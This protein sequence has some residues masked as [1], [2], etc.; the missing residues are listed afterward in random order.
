[1]WT[2]A[3]YSLKL[4]CFPFC[5]NL[6]VRL[7]CFVKGS[8]TKIALHIPI[9]SFVFIFFSHK[10]NPS[11]LALGNQS[12]VQVFGKVLASYWFNFLFP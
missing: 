9:W 5:S 12:Q 7:S 6:V 11:T 8:Q 1:M 2:I 4:D 3:F 10:S